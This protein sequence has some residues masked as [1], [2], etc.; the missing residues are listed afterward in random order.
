MPDLEYGWV[1]V[2]EADIYMTL[3]LNADAIWSSGTSKEAALTT[4]YY[5]LLYCGKFAFPDTATDAM[6]DAQCEQTLFRL[7]EGL[8]FDSRMNLQAQGVQQAG[9]VKETY[10]SFFAKD[11]GVGIPI[12]PIAAGLL[13][14]YRTASVALVVE[15]D[16][17]EDEGTTIPS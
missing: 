17:D 6:K 1:T 15:L 5:D 16:R 14:G 10:R 11:K 8:G 7:Q 9:I 3:R 2:A 4:G 13:S 12:S